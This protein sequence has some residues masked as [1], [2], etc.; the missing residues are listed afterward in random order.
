MVN[1]P[2]IFLHDIILHLIF[3]LEFPFSADET[4]LKM[5]QEVSENF[6]VNKIKLKNPQTAKHHQKSQPSEES[7]FLVL[8]VCW[9]DL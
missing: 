3:L 9:F 2:G 7:V 4:K 1:E 5:M 6:E 8:D